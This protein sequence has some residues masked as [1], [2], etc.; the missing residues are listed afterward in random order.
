MTL[1]TTWQKNIQLYGRAKCKTINHIIRTMNNEQVRTL[2]AECDKRR[3]N[4]EKWFGQDASLE[5]CLEYGLVMRA[6]LPVNN[7]CKYLFECY[8]FV[9]TGEDGTKKWYH[10]TFDYEFWLELLRDGD[11]DINNLAKMCGMTEEEYIN[12]ITPC[13]LL[14]DLISYYGI[15]EVSDYGSA[16]KGTIDESEL[17]K[18]IGLDEQ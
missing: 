13:N 6:V 2:L 16:L 15:I 12:C 8:Y 10:D 7:D 5:W 14:G 3:E 1:P 18:I 11:Y 9:G 4:Y 17:L